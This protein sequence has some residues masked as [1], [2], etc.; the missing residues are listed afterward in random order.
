M[1]NKAIF[2]YQQMGANMIVKRNFAAQVAQHTGVPKEKEYYSI[3]GVDKTATPDRKQ[4]RENVVS[5]LEEG[6]EPWTPPTQVLIAL[7]KVGEHQAGDAHDAVRGERR[8]RRRRVGGDDTRAD[9]RDGGARGRDARREAE[10]D[11]EAD[12]P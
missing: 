8:H 3:L 12:G 7:C 6:D 11:G 1:L 2:K 10:H 4:R 5:L 9:A